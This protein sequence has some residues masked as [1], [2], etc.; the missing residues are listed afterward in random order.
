MRVPTKTASAA[1]DSSRSLSGRN[2]HFAAD[3][4]VGGTTTATNMAR[5]HSARMTT[6]GNSAPE[7][8]DTAGA[9]LP[10]A[11]ALVVPYDSQRHPITH[12]EHRASVATADMC[13]DRPDLMRL[14]AM[15]PVTMRTALTETDITLGA[16][17]S[18]KSGQV[19]NLPAATID[20]IRMRPVLET[21]SKFE[22]TG[23]LG[24]RDGVRALK[25]GSIS[26]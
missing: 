3:A 10:P 14:A 25:I 17:M 1:L 4:E 6:K 8:V 13:L 18:M 22:M 21:K 20:E 26:F 15:A 12:A 19:I 24:N 23:A 11:L 9:E 7:R 16:L 2:S 5:T